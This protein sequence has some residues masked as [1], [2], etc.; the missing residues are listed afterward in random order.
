MP[1]EMPAPV[2]EETVAKFLNGEM[3]EVIA[4]KQKVVAKLLAATES[5]R[6]ALGEKDELHVQSKAKLQ[7]ETTELQRMIKKNEPKNTSWADRSKATA[8]RLQLAMGEVETL[9]ANKKKRR[10]AGAKAAEQ[11]HCSDLKAVDILIEELKERRGRICNQF[12]KAQEA[13]VARRKLLDEHEEEVMRLF[14]SKI[15]AVGPVGGAT[16][17]TP[18][19][20]VPG[21]DVEVPG[22][23]LDSGLATDDEC[24]YAKFEDLNLR[25]D[26][27]AHPVSV[28][29]E[30]PAGQ[31]GIDVDRMWSFFQALP[32]GTQCPPVSYRQLGVTKMS[33]VTAMISEG[34]MKQLY[35]ERSVSP[36]DYAPWQ[37][38]EGI[39]HVLSTAHH[40]L[41]AQ[42]QAVAD[43]KEVLEVAREQS[44]LAKFQRT[45]ARW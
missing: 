41:S 14:N 15:K 34:A 3:S 18:G 17:Q 11:Q 26:T 20:G 4:A 2:A 7:E 37:V 43:A 16:P 13:W 30:K 36:E 45:D 1:P 40:H 29:A 38:M 39:K 28:L 9:Q 23:D 21:E 42:A 25:W 24:D 33:T 12:V 32:W 10:E 27:Q 31:V 44:R 6:L 5:L 8:L 22:D 35:G 19:R